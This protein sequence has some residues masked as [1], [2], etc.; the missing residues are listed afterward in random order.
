[1]QKKFS[2]PLKI[3]ELKQSEYAFV[4]KANADELVDICQVLQVENVH[5]FIA[6]IKLKL[7]VREHLLKI[8]GN[9]TAELELKSV[10]SL[11]NFTQN[12]EVPF[13]LFFDTKATYRD[14]REMGSDINADVPDIAENGIINLADIAMEQIALQIDDYPRAKGEVFVYHS[15]D[16]DNETPHENPFAVLAKLKK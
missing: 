11:E 3:D 14:I 10:I 4:L 15:N 16:E 5:F 13:E 2:Y 12:Y 6:E 9:V 8:W 7:N 1:M